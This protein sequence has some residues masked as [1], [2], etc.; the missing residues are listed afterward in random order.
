MSRIYWNS[1][2]SNQTFLL[3]YQ[4]LL[5]DQAITT[6]VT[7]RQT[8]KYAGDNNEQFHG[9]AMRV[10]ANL[11]RTSAVCAVLYSK[12]I[13]RKCHLENKGQGHRIQH[14]PQLCHSLANNNLCTSYMTL[15]CKSLAVSENLCFQ[16]VTLENLFQGHEVQ[17][18]CSNQRWTTTSTKVV[19]EHFC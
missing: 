2:F 11:L 19:I 17:Q 1:K 18:Y 13:T 6:T 10:K 7:Y 16:F 9:G 3:T 5:L 8:N 14:S 15:F 12:C 4:K